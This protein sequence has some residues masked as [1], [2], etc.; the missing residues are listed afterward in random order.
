[1]NPTVI[2]KIDPTNTSGKALRE[3]TAP[4]VRELGLVTLTAAQIMEFQE[5]AFRAIANPGLQEWVD[6][7]R[8]ASI[9]T[10]PVVRAFSYALALGDPWRTTRIPQ[11]A[12]DR[13]YFRAL[14]RSVYPLEAALAMPDTDMFL[15]LMV[16]SVY[17]EFPVE[18]YDIEEERDTPAYAKWRQSFS[19]VPIA[20]A[21]CRFALHVDIPGNDAENDIRL[22]AFIYEHGLVALRR[23]TS[24]PAIALQ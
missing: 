4:V 10:D 24:V 14:V 15:K 3:A 20:Y 7:V 23:S 6:T 16:L 18:E 13:F 9:L 22:L 8:A 11:G 1:M 17:G 12:I 19:S 21:A 5:F 2:E